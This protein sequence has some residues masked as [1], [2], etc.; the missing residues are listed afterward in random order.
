VLGDDMEALKKFAR[1]KEKK[2]KAV[3]DL[4]K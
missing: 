3:M 2:E 1:Q 4:L